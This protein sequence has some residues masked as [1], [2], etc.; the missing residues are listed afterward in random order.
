MPHSIENQLIVIEEPNEASDLFLKLNPEL[1]ALKAEPILQGRSQLGL[2]V[3]D[4]SGEN[5]V[6]VLY[7]ATQS[8]EHLVLVDMTVDNFP[9]HYQ[10]DA[11]MND[12]DR[13]K[14]YDRLRAEMRG[15]VLRQANEKLLE[16]FPRC[17][18]G[19]RPRVVK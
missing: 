2:T 13:N 6:V 14:L 16:I 11:H 1:L 9:K 17:L 8:S 5:V 4:K 7:Q 19:F 10:F 18:E 3:T 12:F 15:F